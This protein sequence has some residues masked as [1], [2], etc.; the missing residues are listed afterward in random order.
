MARLI[1]EQDRRITWFHCAQLEAGEARRNCPDVPFY[2]G[3][4]VIRSS[5]Q[6][7]LPL[8]LRQG[9]LSSSHAKARLRRQKRT[10]LQR[11][12]LVRADTDG[13]RW[14]SSRR[15]GEPRPGDLVL[16]MIPGQEPAHWLVTP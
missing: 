14:I 12:Y 15:L 6:E 8:G 11:L 5:M 16:Q 1:N 2:D 4:N 9:S 7:K 13:Q 10:D 3:W